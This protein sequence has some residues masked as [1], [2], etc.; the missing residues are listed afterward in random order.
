MFIFKSPLISQNGL[1]A[2]LDTEI[3]DFSRFEV[4]VSLTKSGLAAIDEICGAIFT[5]I[6]MVNENGI[7]N[8][9]FDEVLQI[10]ELEWRFLEKGNPS[11]Y[12]Q[13][14]VS[15]MQKFPPSLYI[16]GS[17][18]ISLNNNDLGKK[19]S[20]QPKMKFD[21]DDDR[22]ASKEAV[23]SFFSKLTVDECMITV[24]SKEFEGKTD[25]VERWYGTN[26]KVTP[27][28]MSTLM[29]WDS[30][31]SA[32]SLGIK[33]PLPNPFIPSEEG[34]IVKEKVDR[35]KL[36]KS[37]S[38]DDR[39]KSIKPPELVRE[40]KADSRWSVWYKQ[41]DRYGQPKA[42]AIFELITPDAYSSPKNAV[43]SQ[44]FD[45]CLSDS[46]DE[47]SYDATLA[48]LTFSLQVLP[49]GVRLTFGGYNDKLQ[50]FASYI[51]R[52][53]ASSFDDV[54]PSD[55]K[56]LDRFKDELS[57]GLSAF[58]TKQPYAHSI[59]YSALAMTPTAFQYSNMDLRQELEGVD[60]KQLRK[61]VGNLWK[62]GQGDALIQGNVN[63]AEALSLVDAVDSAIQFK[64]AVDEDLPPHL[65]A[66]PLPVSN[67]NKFSANIKI[68]EPNA[69][70]SNSASQIVFQVLGK[71]DKEHV[72][73]E[74][75]S[76][77]LEESFYDDLRTR[78]QLGY[79]VSSGLKAIGESRNLSFIV[80][81]SIASAEQ[82]TDAINLYLRNV[83]NKYL[84][85]LNDN[86]IAVNAK[87]LF[88]RKTTPPKTLAEETT[89]NWGEISS[90]RFRFNRVQNEAAMLLDIR[91]ED[92]LKFWD[93]Y[94]MPDGPG[95]R[96]LI[97]ETVPISGPASSLVKPAKNLLSKKD[98][99]EIILG[100]GD[101]DDFRTML[102]TL[103]VE[104]SDGSIWLSSN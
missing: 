42:Y 76:S 53:V 70:N 23:T 26:Y 41:D 38:F 87:A 63:L 95:R 25:K 65:N 11:N 81:S 80:Q 57:R 88:I 101:M 30:F 61:Y 28:S 66:L 104:T 46:L 43:L 54:L 99:T 92:L 48:G 83:R 58:D 8:Y 78:Q 94:F 17:R 3:S 19:V 29:K 9:I 32:S 7:P 71:S 56:E 84:E 27:I 6:K 82:L 47:Y 75:L 79:I 20:S 77:V 24:L 21:S 49:R 60:L 73:I 68:S 39:L 85:K 51:S 37:L 69:S 62:R 102:E 36:S 96:M 12:V 89:R 86:D 44:L 40:G 74:L 16:A 1:G 64:T 100:I 2:S 103:T 13:S 50:D 14:L 22:N 33:F 93:F 52:K 10:N 35:T 18:R 59:Y 90:G 91:K 45:I 15:G 98:S 31:P 72:L 4:D 67:E 5:Y 55:D 97:S 34:L